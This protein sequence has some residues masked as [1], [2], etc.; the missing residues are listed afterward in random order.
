MKSCPI[1]QRT[2]SDSVSYCSLD[3]AALLAVGEIADPYVG[4]LIKNSYQV[5]SKLGAGGFGTVYLAE[6]ISIGRKVALKFLQGTNALND[7]LV[8][9]FR[10]EARATARL[11]HPNIV[12]VYDFAQAEDRSLFIVMEYIDGKSLTDVI[13]RKRS[14]E[15]KRVVQ[16]A[17]QLA[18]GL[19][20]AHK[21]GVIH[22]DIK[23]SNIMVSEKNGIERVKVMDFG[24]A[25]LSDT[26]TMT[27]ITAIGSHGPGTPAYM[28]PEQADGIPADYKS[29]IYSYG[30]VLYEMLCSRV[31]FK[32]ATP[33]AV[34]KMQIEELPRDVGDL[35]P[36]VPVTLRK[37]VM[38][39]L[40]KRPEKRPRSM[41]EISQ[42]LKSLSFGDMETTHLPSHASTSTPRR[43][44]ALPKI[45]YRWLWGGGRSALRSGPADDREHRLD[46]SSCK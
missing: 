41:E 8:A 39:M 2:Y 12:T 32:A 25:R 26:S 18:E 3:G 22:R 16:L 42:T 5:L 40:A 27:P 36:D 28:S 20:A 37:L 19:D 35:R 34:L 38:Q 30:I 6:Q 13:R 29:D 4:K 15:L 7:E 43:D 17:I 10:L 24:I 45:D 14:L 1:C 9:R 33:T 11:D 44:F 21:A 23:P 31:P 46:E